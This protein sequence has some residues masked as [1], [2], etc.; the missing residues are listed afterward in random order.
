MEGGIQTLAKWFSEDDTFAQKSG[1]LA[2][3]TEV[4]AGGM[5]RILAGGEADTVTL[6]TGAVQVVHAGG[7]VKN[8]TIENRANSWVSAGAMLEGKITVKDSGQLHL[9]A[10][11]N[12]HQ[13]TVEDIDLSGENAR[14]YS[15]SDEF[16]DKR[17]LH[18]KVKRCRR[19]CFYFCWR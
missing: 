5:Q 3:N 19:N 13:T 18:S 11:D 8:L 14:L 6:Y 7:Y 4:F 2:I 12:D 10:G 9:D 15:I 1:G 16:D 17:F